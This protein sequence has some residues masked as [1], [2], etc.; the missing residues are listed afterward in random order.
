MRMWWLLFTIDWKGFYCY[1]VNITAVAWPN[2]C[3]APLNPCTFIVKLPICEIVYRLSSVVSLFHINWMTSCAC[4]GRYSV[5][6]HQNISITGKNEN[7]C[8]CE[9]FVYSIVIRPKQKGT[10]PPEKSR[11]FL[12]SSFPLMH[13][14]FSRIQFKL[15]T[16]QNKT[17]HKKFHFK[18]Q[19]KQHS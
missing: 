18:W 3:N 16:V 7:L 13:H 9:S 17:K 8:T 6:S 1:D 11:A 19:Q 14:L 5:T 4:I 2:H 12:S 15:R 10:D